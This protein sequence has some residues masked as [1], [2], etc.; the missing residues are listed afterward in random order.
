[1]HIQKRKEIE[2]VFWGSFAWDEIEFVC[3]GCHAAF[4]GGRAAPRNPPAQIQFGTK[5]NELKS[6][7]RI[8]IRFFTVKDEMKSN[9][10]IETGF[11]TVENEMKSNFREFAD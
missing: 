5:K 4:G 6:K 7:W 11:C 2:N 9:L 1:L 8:E 10:R 3:W